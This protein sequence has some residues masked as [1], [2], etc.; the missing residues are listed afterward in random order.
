MIEFGPS[1]KQRWENKLGSGSRQNR[2]GTSGL[3]DIDITLLLIKIG[4]NVLVSIVTRNTEVR[5]DGKG[6]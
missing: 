5:T 1:V 4:H 3:R 2:H 6:P